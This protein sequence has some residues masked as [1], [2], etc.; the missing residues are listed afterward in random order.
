LIETGRLRDD[1]PNSSVIG[2]ESSSDYR[3]C[4]VKII[5]SKVEERLYSQYVGQLW[6][7]MLL[8]DGNGRKAFEAYCRS[9]M[10]PQDHNTISLKARQMVSVGR[11]TASASLRALGGCHSIKLALDIV[12]ACKQTPLVVFHSVDRA[13]DLIDF[14]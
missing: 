6:Q 14:I 7:Q 8:T 1:Q 3:A 13:F 4:S 11:T 2:L 10:T 12:E 5:S 9:L